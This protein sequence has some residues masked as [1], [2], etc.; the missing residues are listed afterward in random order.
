MGVNFVAFDVFEN[1]HIQGR[2]STEKIVAWFIK[3]ILGDHTY[4]KSFCG[5]CFTISQ[6]RELVCTVPPIH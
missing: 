3:K 5:D 4:L 1:I 6:I 2:N